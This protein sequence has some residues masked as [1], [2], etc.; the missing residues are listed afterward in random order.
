MNGYGNT[1]AYLNA[2]QAG[3]VMTR[4]GKPPVDASM[5]SPGVSVSEYPTKAHYVSTSTSPGYDPYSPYY[6]PMLDGAA[7]GTDG[8]MTEET[9]LFATSAASSKSWMVYP[10]IGLGVLALGFGVYYY[11]SK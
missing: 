9:A 10:A 11:T 8:G 3:S 5:R 1:P 2:G 7:G 4:D 6:D